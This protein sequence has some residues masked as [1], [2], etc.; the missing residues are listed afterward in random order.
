MQT[1]G[2]QGLEG[3]GKRRKCLM[4]PAFYFGVMEYVGTRYRWCLL[5]VLSSSNF[6]MVNVM[7][8]SPRY[9]KNFFSDAALAPP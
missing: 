2:C 8:M 4:G 9:I 5:N 6:K 7:L 3:G 1:G